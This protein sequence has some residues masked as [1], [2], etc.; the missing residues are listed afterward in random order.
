MNV[1]AA[2]LPGVAR[3]GGEARGEEGRQVE[4]VEWIS[5]VK[6]LSLFGMSLSFESAGQLIS[7]FSSAA[8][9]SGSMLGCCERSV[10]LHASKPV[11]NVSSMSSTAPVTVVAEK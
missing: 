7:I 6:E 2:S 5:R 10:S 1:G 11:L 3:L 8:C 4:G 9:A